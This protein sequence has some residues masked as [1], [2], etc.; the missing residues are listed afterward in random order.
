MTYKGI[1]AEGSKI[2]GVSSGLAG[3]TLQGATCFQISSLGL[4]RECGPDIERQLKHRGLLPPR[5]TAECLKV[6]LLQD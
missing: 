3:C 1:Q 6:E 4:D 5:F 2:E